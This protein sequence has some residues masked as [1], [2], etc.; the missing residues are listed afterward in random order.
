[1]NENKKKRLWL[2]WERQR[3]TLELAKHFKCKLIALEYQGIKRI[4]LSIFKTISLIISEKP[5]VLFVQNPSMILAG[6]GCI[7]KYF[8]RKCLVVDRHSNFMITK[9]KWS[10]SYKVLF[11]ILN[12]FTIKNANLTIVTN[13]FIAEKVKRNGG[14]AFI[15]QDKIPHLK[16]SSNVILKGKNNVMFIASHHLDEPLNDVINAIKSIQDL[17]LYLYVTGDFNKVKK[18]YLKT[19]KNIVFT[20]FLPNNEFVNLIYAVDVVL[21]LT[22]NEN[23]LLCGCYEAIA[24]EKPLITSN[25]VALKEYFTTAVF[26]DNNYKEIAK[27]LKDTIKNI[28]KH[29]NNIRTLKVDLKEKWEIKSKHLEEIIS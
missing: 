7:Y 22:K 10:F 20:G 29:Q 14:N 6:L 8:Y 24:A 4:P 9:R 2:A 12:K 11:L 19:P 3:R 1:M 13:R 26:V 16:K 28:E 15:L 17:D 23:F 21:V 18:L 5:D 25:T 27:G